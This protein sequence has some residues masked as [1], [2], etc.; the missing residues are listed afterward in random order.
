MGVN[1]VGDRIMRALFVSAS[2][3]MIFPMMSCAA[4]NDD[5]YKDNF[6]APIVSTAN[7]WNWVPFDDAKCGDGSSVG[8]GINPSTTS[9]RVLIYLEGGG[10]CYNSLTCYTLQ[11]ASYFT[12]G[13]SE[14]DFNAEVASTDYISKSGGFFDRTAATNPFKDYSFVYVPY[15]T[16]DIHAGNSVVQ[17]D[18][19]TAYFV[20]FKNMQLFLSNLYPTFRNADRVVLT[21]SSAGGFGAVLN[22][23]QTQRAFGN[24]R[25]DMIDDSGAFMPPDIQAMGNGGEATAAGVWNLPST[26]P[27]TCTTC[28]T[29]ITTIFDFYSTQFPT[30]RG[31]LLSYTQDSVLPTYDG[32]TTAE[33]T[34]GLDEL[35]ADQFNASSNPNLAYFNAAGSG[36][37]LWFNPSLS[38]D[39][40]SVLQFITLMESDSASWQSVH[41]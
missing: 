40:V 22:W 18:G 25:V 2:A 15:C 32:I 5:V 19:Q 20:G 16:G 33:F 14:T 8:L 29:D 34:A 3:A 4:S 39:S 28:S 7:A 24:V 37:V 9:S 10:E 23:W 13:Y 6:E 31:A 36:H 21:G 27:P 30:S 38:T 17:L 41:P 12:T 1:S 26:R 35:E 11:T